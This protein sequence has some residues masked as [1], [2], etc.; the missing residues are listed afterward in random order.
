[1][2]RLSAGSKTGSVSGQN[3][4]AG[5][6]RPLRQLVRRGLRRGRRKS[7]Q[8]GVR[9]ARFFLTQYTKTGENIPNCNHIAKWP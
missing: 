7:E 6:L 9:V 2:T 5:H 3:R 8:L 1:M 4:G